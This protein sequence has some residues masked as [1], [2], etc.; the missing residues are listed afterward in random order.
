MHTFLRCVVGIYW[1]AVLCKPEV[2]KGRVVPVGG[3]GV[4]R[5]QNFDREWSRTKNREPS[6]KVKFLLSNFFLW[7]RPSKLHPYRQKWP[8][9]HIRG[10][11]SRVTVI[12]ID[13]Q[14]FTKFYPLR[15]FMR[16]NPW[17]QAS[18]GNGSYDVCGGDRAWITLG[19]FRPGTFLQLWSS[20]SKWMD[21]GLGFESPNHTHP[22]PF[23]INLLRKDPNVAL[24]KIDCSSFFLFVFSAA[25]PSMV[26]LF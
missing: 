25:L 1:V 2:S 21:T 19:K 13:T 10:L 4:V 14:K 18:W 11:S 17:S 6:N 23:I 8:R 9:R 26:S 16:S 20:W 5:Q 12:G 7:L 15:E 3:K 22:S 24:S